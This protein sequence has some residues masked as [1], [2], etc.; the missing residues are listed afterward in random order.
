M[1]ID[2]LI[3]GLNDPLILASSVNIT[4]SS[5][6]DV[7]SINLTND[8]EELFSNVGQQQLVLLI[9]DVTLEL[10]NTMYTCEVRVMLDTGPATITETVTLRVSSKGY[11]KSN[12]PIV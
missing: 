6:L 10:N 2:I 7:Q 5:D 11:N 9:E 8:G 3:F 4:C 1:S 12:L